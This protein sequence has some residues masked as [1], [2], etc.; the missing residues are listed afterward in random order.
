MKL[1]QDVAITPRVVTAPVQVRDK[2]IIPMSSP[3]HV[4]VPSRRTHIRRDSRSLLRRFGNGARC[5]ARNLAAAPRAIQIV[6]IAATVLAVFSATNLIYQVARKPTEMFFPVSGALDKTPIETW[7]QYAPLFREY[8]TAIIT[9]EL[10]AALAQVE[11]TGNPLA[12]TYWRWRLAWDPFAI[13]Q[14]ASTSVGMYQ[15]TDGA[16]VKTRR[17]C[18]RGHAV[19]ESGCWWNGLYTRVVPSHAIELTAVF[20]DRSVAEILARRPGEATQQ[21]KQE[22]AAIIHLC[23]AGPARVFARR[24]FSLT[25]GERCGDQDPAAYLAQ[26]N[27]MKREFLR[28]AANR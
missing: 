2:R 18:I 28:L 12:N 20:L 24:G 26:F 25:P 5:L 3:R 23:G 21:Q 7:R 17:Y 6:A 1:K 16:F 9:P 13:Y 11:S 4:R 22:L 19:I 27:A 8:S 14:P 10:L 15:M